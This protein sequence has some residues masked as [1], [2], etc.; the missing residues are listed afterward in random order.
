M[1][2]NDEVNLDAR[3]RCQWHGLIVRQVLFAGGKIVCL[4]RDASDF[5][6]KLAGRFHPDSHKAKILLHFLHLVQ[7]SDIWLRD[8]ME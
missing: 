2:W 6:Q 1:A 5:V 8:R 4:G 7:L 3:K